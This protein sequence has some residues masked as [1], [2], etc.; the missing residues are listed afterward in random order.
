MVTYVAFLRGTNSGKN[1]MLKMDV[2]KKAFEKLGFQNVRT[3]ISS[4]NVIFETERTDVRALERTIE[5][6]L[7]KAIG[8]ES[9][10]IV[11]KLADLQKLEKLNVFK[12]IEATRETRQFVTFVK[13]APKSSPKLDGE[14]FTILKKSGRALLS[15]IELSGLRTPDMMKVLDQEFGRTNTTR[16]WK[17][18]QRILQKA[19]VS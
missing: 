11:Y 6:A 1:P 9:A 8:F 5:K 15:V 18:I 19:G 16:T 12:D 7:P 14:G 2:L 10:T 13:E 17:T 3:V 4:G